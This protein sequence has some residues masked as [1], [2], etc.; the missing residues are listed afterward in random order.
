VEVVVARF[1]NFHG[2]V[3][4]HLVLAH[5]A[6]VCDLGRYNRM[7][8]CG[9]STLSRTEFVQLPRAH[10]MFGRL[11]HIA[12]IHCWSVNLKDE[13]LTTRSN[14]DIEQ[15]LNLVVFAD[16]T[17]NFER[18]LV[19]DTAADVVKLRHSF[20]QKIFTLIEHIFFTTLVDFLEKLFAGAFVAIFE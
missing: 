10:F 8:G 7:T 17:K 18:V 5:D 2:V 19:R 16:E 15:L 20:Y 1:D 6:D 14:L 3:G 12:L 9:A 13:L 4:F 11:S